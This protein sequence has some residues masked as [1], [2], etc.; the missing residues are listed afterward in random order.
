MN[1]L[2]KS[3][4]KGFDSYASVVMAVRL[5]PRAVRLRRRCLAPHAGLHGLP[6]P[7]CSR[8][9]VVSSESALAS[10]FNPKLSDT[11]VPSRSS[12]SIVGSLSFHSFSSKVDLFFYTC[13]SIQYSSYR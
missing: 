8:G 4:L 7:M 11:R 10:A 5:L 1:F 12:A 13:F 3:E 6:T 9:R 2:V